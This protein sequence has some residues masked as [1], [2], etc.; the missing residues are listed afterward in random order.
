MKSIT[1]KI[2]QDALTDSRATSG[3]TGGRRPVSAGEFRQKAQPLGGACLSFDIGR[4]L[5]DT[6]TMFNPLHHESLLDCRAVE[7]KE[8]RVL[9]NLTSPSPWR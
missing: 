3:M 6:A 1:N 7:I 5:F 4:L 2:S 8:G 9:L